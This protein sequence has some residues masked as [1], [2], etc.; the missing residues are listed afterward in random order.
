M[1][2]PFF[3]RLL[4]LSH[5]SAGAGRYEVAFHL[6]SAAMHDAEA[7]ADLTA[8]DQVAKVCAAQAAALDAIEPPH[9][10]SSKGAENRG[11]QPLYQSLRNL[12]EIVRTR[13]EARA[14]L[15]EPI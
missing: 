11:T 15:D 6:L 10:L 2:S 4:N 12:I 13:L 3:D 1:P 8:L 7:S 14:T 9:A 5:E